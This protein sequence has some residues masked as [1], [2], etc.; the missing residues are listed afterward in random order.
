M[1]PHAVYTSYSPCNY[2]QPLEVLDL[3]SLGVLCLKANTDPED[4]HRKWGAVWAT[5]P[6][7]LEQCMVSPITP[8]EG[9]HST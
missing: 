2:S 7:C 5:E 8:D 9:L 3:G 1:G 6:L 4:D